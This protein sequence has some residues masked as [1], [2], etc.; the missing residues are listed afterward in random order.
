[1]STRE[2]DLL[3]IKWL[4]DELK[5]AEDMI[6]GRIAGIT[7]RVKQLEAALIKAHDIIDKGNT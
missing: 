1:M 7:A 3:V 5:A 4:R 2:L 6:E